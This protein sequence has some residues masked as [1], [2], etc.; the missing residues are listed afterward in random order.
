[1]TELYKA[2]NVYYPNYLPSF[3]KHFRKCFEK[4]MD[5]EDITQQNLNLF[6]AHLSDNCAKS[7]VKT[8]CNALKAVISKYDDTI[9]VPYKKFNK[10]LVIFLSFVKNKTFIISCRYD[11]G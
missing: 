5:F 11:R 8:Y 10:T 7:S 3:R 9:Q 4:D 6:V 2:I 1:M